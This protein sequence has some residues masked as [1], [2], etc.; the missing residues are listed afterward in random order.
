MDKTDYVSF[1]FILALLPMKIEINMK[2]LSK[3]KGMSESILATSMQSLSEPDKHHS[4]TIDDSYATSYSGGYISMWF[5]TKQSQLSLPNSIEMKTG[6]NRH[7]KLSESQYQEQ[8]SSS[9]LSIGSHFHLQNDPF[10]TDFISHQVQM[11]HH[12]N[13]PLDC[14]SYPSAGSYI[15]RMTSSYEPNAV[16]YPQMMVLAPTTRAVLPIDSRGVLL[17]IYVNAKQY[18]AIIRRRQARA[19]LEAQNKITKSRKPYLHESRH[20]HALKRARGSGG[21]FLNTKSLQKPNPSTR[22][23]DRRNQISHTKAPNSESSNRWGAHTP[24]SSNI[25]CI[26]NDDDNIFQQPYLGSSIDSLT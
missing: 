15:R 26:F 19:K 18:H 12:H 9:T 21:R 17:P 8:G 13:Q 23:V 6:Y 11:E 4:Q 1:P 2:S 7:L 10:Q 20:R 3:T 5:P 24:Y 22:M 16:V 14:I 25:S